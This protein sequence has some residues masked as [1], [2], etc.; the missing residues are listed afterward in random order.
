MDQLAPGSRKQVN[1]LNISEVIQNSLVWD[2]HGCMPLRPEESTLNFLPLLQRYRDGGVDVASLNVTFDI[3]G[4]DPLF[5][6]RILGSSAI[7]TCQSSPTAP[8]IVHDPFV[9]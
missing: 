5:G 6:F 2:N 4:V 7:H 8:N 1:E 9:D 3:P